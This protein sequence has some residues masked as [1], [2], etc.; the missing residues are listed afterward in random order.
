M[1]NRNRHRRLYEYVG[2]EIGV[3]IIE[4]EYQPGDSLPNEDG[5]CQAFEVSRGVVR[6]AV[7]VLTSKGLVRPRP[8][9]GT[10]VQP[11]SQWNLFD[12]D[13][14]QWMLRA[15]HQLDFLKKVTEVRSIIESEAAKLAA[16]KA[17]QTEIQSILDL[18]EQLEAMLGK[19]STYVYEAYLELDMQFH[20][21]IL[22]ASHNEILAS[23]GHTMRQA[24]HIARQ[25]DT[26]DLKNQQDSMPF[27]TAVARAI[28][29]HDPD[30]AYQASSDMLN[31]VWT[32]IT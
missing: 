12:A 18:H 4:G 29:E 17:S 26:R 14:L 2:E 25:A 13:V 23:L 27:H 8:K 9:I 1:L 10:Q 3:K 11:R 19:S 32:T 7:K 20:L 5:L 15:G 28:A 6:E 22:D 31:F 30:T 16:L 24:V 21:A